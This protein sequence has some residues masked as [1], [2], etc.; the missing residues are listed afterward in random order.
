LALGI[1]GPADPPPAL[2]AFGYSLAGLGSLVLVVYDAVIGLWLWRAARGWDLDQ[3]QPA[4]GMQ[5]G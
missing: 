4:R 5:G 1:T 2:A 3:T